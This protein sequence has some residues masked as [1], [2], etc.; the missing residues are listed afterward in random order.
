MRK[1]MLLMAGLWCVMAAVSVV[2]AL[3][4]APALRCGEVFIV[5]GDDEYRVLEACG[6]PK[7]IQRGPG[8]NQERWIYD[9]GPEEFIY[10]L[11]FTDGRLERI[12]TGN[13][14]GP[15]S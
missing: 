3:D 6:E 10:Y 2:Y 8:E 11:D 1:R 4:D 7:M 13:Y 15:P 14:G 5:R 9:F 12:Q